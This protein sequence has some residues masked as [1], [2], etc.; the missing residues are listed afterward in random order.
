MET[1]DKRVYAGYYKRYDGQLVYVISTAK[2]A[3]TDED[4]VIYTP[5]SLTKRYGYFTI[6][7]KSFCEP[8][9]VKGKEV[10]KFRRQTQKTPSA[11]MI[12]YVKATGF[13]GP[14][15]RQPK[16][17]DYNL[18]GRSYQNSPTYYEYAR[19]ICKNYKKDLEAINEC[20]TLKR[21]ISLSKDNFHK[22]YEDIKLVKSSIGTVLKDYKEFFHEH[23][24]QGISIRKYAERHGINRGSVELIQ[25]KLFKELAA[26]L[27]QRDVSEGKC[28]IK[29]R[30]KKG[31]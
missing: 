25:K 23:F 15:R 9:I 17:D 22:A 12:N 28:R 27:Y 5:Y 1:I 13:R 16:E 11:D 6:S 26:I 2:D 31:T 4:T 20:I 8:V 3:D 14:I 10:P 29:P 19:D 7:K 18:Y 30:K 21:Y 24:V